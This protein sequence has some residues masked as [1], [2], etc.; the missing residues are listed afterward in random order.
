MSIILVGGMDRLGNRYLEAAKDLG[1]DLRI[2]SQAMAPS[3]T[4]TG[5]AATKVERNPLPNGS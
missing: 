1:M 5:N 2:F 3:N 4:T